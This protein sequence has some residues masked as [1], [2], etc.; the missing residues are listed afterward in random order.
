MQI[1][2]GNGTLPL[3]FAQRS[4]NRFDR[5]AEVTRNVLASH[6]QFDALARARLSP[7]GEA[8]EKRCYALLRVFAAKDHKV[9][10]HSQEMLD[11]GIQNATNHLRFG[12]PE[13][14][15]FA[16]RIGNEHD[17]GDGFCG[18]TVFASLHE[19]KNIARQHEIRNL[20]APISRVGTKPYR[21]ADDLERMIRA[22]PLAKD[23]L[24][25]CEAHAS[26]E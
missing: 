26:A 15:Y 6:R 10:P 8:Q 5:K 2:R 13:L 19:A 23:S 9:T 25:S 11:Q 21:A 20:T 7:F 1:G 18:E 3:E 24:V 17:V 12:C 14:V 4:T 22:I 16:A